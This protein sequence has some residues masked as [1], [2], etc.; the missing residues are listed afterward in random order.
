MSEHHFNDYS[1]WHEWSLTIMCFEFNPIHWQSQKEWYALSLI[2]S[3]H[4]LL[5][6]LINSLPTVDAAESHYLEKIADI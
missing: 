4:P 6:L 1:I 3:F 2:T 5:I